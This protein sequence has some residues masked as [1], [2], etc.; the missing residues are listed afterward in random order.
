VRQGP[1]V[2]VGRCRTRINDWPI[3]ALRR[4]YCSRTGYLLPF[5]RR[6][7]H[8]GSE[9]SESE[10]YRDVDDTN[11]SD[12]GRPLDRKA[13]QE[14]LKYRVCEIALASVLTSVGHFDPQ[15]PHEDGGVLATDDMDFALEQVAQYPRAC[16]WEVEVQLVDAWNQRKIG[17]AEGSWQC[18]TCFLAQV[19]R[20]LR[21]GSPIDCARA[22]PSVDVRIAGT[23]EDDDGQESALQRQLPNVDV[24]VVL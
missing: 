21:D 20:T 15:L 16:E 8:D 5:T 18:S 12:S 9:V 2:G 6:L 14:I 24:Q 1:N 17:V 22:Q 3:R 19:S 23:T 7:I 4:R 11:C 10:P 13:S